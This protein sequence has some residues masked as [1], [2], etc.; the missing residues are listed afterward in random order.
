MRGVFNFIIGR[1]KPTPSEVAK[2]RVKVG[3]AHERLH[4]EIRVTSELSKTV[5][6]P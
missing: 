6:S 3:L 2:E 4:G 5:C 1:K